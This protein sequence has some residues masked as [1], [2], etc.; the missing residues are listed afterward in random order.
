MDEILKGV[1]IPLFADLPYPL[2]YYVYEQSL[3]TTPDRRA[4]YFEYVRLELK[5]HKHEL[6]VTAAVKKALGEVGV[7]AP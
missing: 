6:A 1:E 3:M 5:D 7:L 4:E 2:Q